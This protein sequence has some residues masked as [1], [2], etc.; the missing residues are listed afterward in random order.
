MQG[1]RK[2][3]G[4]YWLLFLLSSVALGVAI[5]S[6]WP[7]LTLILPFQATFFVMAMDII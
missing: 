6:H 7:W 2:N 1:R 3:K 5:V 4:L